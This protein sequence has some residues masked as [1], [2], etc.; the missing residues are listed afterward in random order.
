MSSRL[1]AGGRSL[2]ALA[3]AVILG[4]SATAIAQTPTAGTGTITGKVTEKG[5]KDPVAYANVVV[6]GT[7]QGAQTGDD[8]GYTI[9]NVPP[10]TYQVKVLGMGYEPV[11]KTVTVNAGQA[12]Q[13][14]VDLGGG[15]KVVK[16]VE[17]IVVTAQKLI[18]TKSST[19]KQS[20]LGETLKDLPVENLQRGHRPQGRRRRH[21]G[22]ELHFRGGRG[23]EVKFQVDGVEVRDPLFGQQRQRSRTWPSPA[24]TCSR[25]ASTPST[26]TRSRAS[27]TCT[28]R[29]GGDKFGGEVQWHTDR[30]GET[31]KTFN[32]Y[33]RFT[34]G[35]GGP[36]PIKQPDLLRAPTKA[37]SRDTYLKSGMTESTPQ[38]SSTSSGSATASRTR[39]TRTSSSR[40]EPNPSEKVTFEDDQQPRRSTRP[41]NHMWSRKGYVAVTYDTAQA[42]G[43]PNATRPSYGT[44]SFFPED[45]TYQSDEHA[46]P[47]ADDR[48]ARSASS[49]RVW[50]HQLSTRRRVHGPRWRASSSTTTAR[51]ATRSRGSTT[52]ARRSTGRGN[53]SDRTIR[54]TPPTATT[55][56]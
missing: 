50:T 13:L 32:N 38:R 17:E 18:D 22:G 10:G 42:D 49:R 6:L 26:A 21:Q 46:R 24:P 51:W 34:F 47:R 9:H 45:S 27:S 8:G 41:Y 20:D 39:S 1:R 44:W 53:A 52:R 15:Q 56:T 31:D 11:T 33:D 37:R 19:T 5:G 3:L 43:Q 12:A 7:K 36:T 55:R 16:Q 2:W 48:R 23:G 30:Y 40:I 35:F 14:S 29:E 28:T 25:A 54:S 4:S